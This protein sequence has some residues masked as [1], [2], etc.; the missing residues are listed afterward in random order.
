MARWGRRALVVGLAGTLVACGVARTI[1]AGDA[2]VLV[3]ERSSGGMDAL[4]EG[5]LTMVG[6]CL[7]IEATEGSALLVVVWPYGT[8]V[9]RGDPLT[10]DLPD[11]GT[12]SLGEAVAVG[13]GVVRPDSPAGPVGGAAIPASCRAPEVWLASS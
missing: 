12:V 3:A 2:R 7:G 10:L 11:V 6:A 4:L 5:T 8:D 13:G 1:E 9:E